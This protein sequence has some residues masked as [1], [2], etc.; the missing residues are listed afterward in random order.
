M[1]THTR[2]PLAV[3]ATAI[4][5]VGAFVSV[6]AYAAEGH[7]ERTLSVTGPVDLD[8]RTGSGD[9]AV[10]RGKAGSLLVKARI[11]TDGHLD[12]ESA[13]K[14]V[15]A[16]EANPPIKQDGDVIK[17]GEFEDSSLARNVS[18]SY[19]IT[20][21]AD[22][23]LRSSTGSGDQTLEGLKRQ[24]TAS[25]G[26]GDLKVSNIGDQVRVSTGSGHISVDRARSG[27]HASTGSGDILIA[28]AVGNLRAST[29]SGDVTVQ[30]S[31]P[32]DVQVNSASGRVQINGVDGSLRVQTASG[33]V[34]VQGKGSGSWKLESA[35]G[36]MDIHLAPEQGFFL[37][38]HTVSGGIHT[39]REMT[40]QGSMGEHNIEGKVGDGALPLE[41]RTVSGNI[42]VD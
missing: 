2:R 40:V 19:E 18:I 32:G 9:I 6:R 34:S 14:Q 23:H 12:E 5:V 29:G 21:P 30:Q 16:I 25:S 7:F 20:T 31:G 37:R 38:A 28:Q 24:V 10:R 27:V 35:S 39:G 4:A 1:S 15:R 36:N 42:Q 13:Q 11:K 8:V 41:V 26:S 3:L 22:T 17:I 33:N